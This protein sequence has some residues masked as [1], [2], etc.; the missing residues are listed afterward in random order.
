MIEKSKVINEISLKI[1]D[2]VDEQILRQLF[3]SKVIT[4]NLIVEDCN[5]SLEYMW[6]EIIQ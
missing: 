5:H 1:L 6:P 2:S 3:S 4:I